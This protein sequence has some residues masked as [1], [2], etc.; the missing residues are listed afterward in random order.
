MPSLRTRTV[1]TKVTE[2]DYAHVVQWRT[3]DGYSDRERLAVEYAELFALDHHALDEPFYD[4]MRASTFTDAEILD[5]T[6]CIGG[7]LA[8]GRTL[9]VLGIDSYESP[10][11]ARCSSTTVVGCEIDAVYPESL[12]SARCESAPIAE[13][14]EVMPRLDASDSQL[15]APAWLAAAI[16]LT[17]RVVRT[18][19]P[20]VAAGRHQSTATAIFPAVWL[21]TLL[22][23]VSEF[24]GCG[25]LP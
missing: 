7:W 14:F 9:H 6:V 5:L 25:T 17:D 11:P 16:Q 3:Y 4:R 18:A 1:S 13:S 8:L 15:T 20:S 22:D 23:R 21:D 24:H 10:P 19:R 12:Q 2:D